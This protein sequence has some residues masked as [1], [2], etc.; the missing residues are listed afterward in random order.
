MTDEKKPE[1]DPNAKFMLMYAADV[2]QPPGK[3][4]SELAHFRSRVGLFW[5]VMRNKQARAAV[6]AN[7]FHIAVITG[8]SK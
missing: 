3:S 5:F 7:R 1:L 6:L 8:T 2:T 4:P